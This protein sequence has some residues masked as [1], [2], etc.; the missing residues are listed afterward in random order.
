MDAD[1]GGE[2]YIGAGGLD[3]DESLEQLA[4]VF[5]FDS[6]QAVGRHFAQ[7]VVREFL[8][9]PV[10]EGFGA[11]SFLQEGTD[12]PQT[13]SFVRF[14][15]LPNVHQVKVGK[16]WFLR[17]WLGGGSDKRCVGLA[18]WHERGGSLSGELVGSMFASPSKP[19]DIQVYLQ[20]V[21]ITRSSY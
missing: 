12:V 10:F 21:Q 15:Q 4:A 19:L 11:H 13:G 3:V 8:A 18:P 14:Q 9:V 5:Q 7:Q 16:W 6:P 20:V 2:R 1:Q 17:A